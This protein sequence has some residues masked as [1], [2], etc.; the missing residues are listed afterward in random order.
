MQR[1]RQAD[2]ETDRQTEI[3]TVRAQR[4][5]QTDRQET[6]RD[7]ERGRDR[8]TETN[9]RKEGGRETDRVRDNQREPGALI[10]P[11]ATLCT[12]HKICHRQTVLSICLQTGRRP[13]LSLS[14]ELVLQLFVQG[15]G[16]VFSYSGRINYN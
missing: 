4:K 5:R 16:A 15:C 14:S 11:F 7:T 2:R 8:E 10:N 9:I 13:T 6:D 12:L 3:Q 1:D